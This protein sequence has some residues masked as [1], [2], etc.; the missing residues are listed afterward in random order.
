M[1]PCPYCKEYEDHR[2]DCATVATALVAGMRCPECNA[3]MRAIRMWLGPAATPTPYSEIKSARSWVTGAY[4]VAGMVHSACCEEC[5][6][7]RL[8]A[9]PSEHHPDKLLPIPASEEQTEIED[10]PLPSRKQ[11]ES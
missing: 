11:G 8:F 10:L 4:P 7:V 9:V 6:H 2:G 1:E 5:R 3:P